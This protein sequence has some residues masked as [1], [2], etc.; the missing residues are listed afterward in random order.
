[1]KTTKK[2]KSKTEPQNKTLDY[3]SLIKKIAENG[4]LLILGQKST[5]KTTLLKHICREL[6]KDFSNHV[7]IFETF[8]KWVNEFDII[9]FMVIEDANVQPKENLPYMQ[10]DY[11]YIQWSKDYNIT[12]EHEVLQFMKENRNCLFLIECEDMEKIS[13]FMS[14][15][16]YQ[17]YRKQ[18]LRAK[19]GTLEN[20][21]E[22]YLFLAEESHNF[23]ILPQF[24][25]RLSRNYEKNR[26][27]LET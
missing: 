23:L 12:N 7:I 18:Y 25:R 8:P 9:P 20:V 14:F 15:V 3:N 4:D 27:N 13:A 5:C 10:E 19:A 2:T 16:I 22:N 17:I 1:M 11:S 24:K 6:M 26:T 21:N